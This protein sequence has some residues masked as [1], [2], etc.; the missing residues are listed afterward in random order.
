MGLHLLDIYRSPNIGIFMRANDRFLL[1]PKG[2]AQT[3]SDKLCEA[4]QVTAVPT[5]IWES[6]LLG[7]LASMNGNGVLVSRLAED[8]EIAEIRSATGLNVSRLESKL[9]AAGNLVVANDRRAIASPALEP[10]ALAQVKDILGTEVERVPIR[11]YHQVGSLAVATNSG[12]AVYPGLDEAE[13]ARLGDLLGVSA[14][15][16]SVN[17]GVPYVA[18]GLVANSR[19]AVAGSLT[20]GPELVFITRA[21]SV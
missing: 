1:L 4:L 20:T 8:A 7:A 17:G 14:Y 13:A 21:L 12:A 18:S 11:E 5:S 9:T 6:R 3:K 10:R 19:N 2:L 15:P 16:T